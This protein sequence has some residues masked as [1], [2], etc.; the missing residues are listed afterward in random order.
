MKASLHTAML[1]IALASEPAIAG[2]AGAIASP[3]D[4][5]ARLR[6]AEAYNATVDFQ[7]LTSLHDDV[8]YTIDLYATAAP[9]DTLAPCNYLIR[10]ATAAS[11]SSGFVAYFSGSIY[12]FRGERLTEQHYHHDPTPF[13]PLGNAPRAQLS[14]QFAELLPHFL[15]R[16]LTEIAAQP[17]HAWHFTADT[18]VDGRR[19]VAL[20]TRLTV[21]DATA[22]ERLLAFDAETAMPIYAETL[23]NPG[24]LTEQ[25]VAA[26]YGPP[27]APLAATLSEPLLAAMYPEVFGRYRTSTYT[28]DNLPGQQLP[29]FALPTLGGGHYAY[30]DPA[31]RRR[32]PMIVVMLD[33]EATL[34]RA[35]V[36]AVRTAQQRMPRNATI[37][38]AAT[39]NDLTAIAHLLLPLPADDAD[40]V[41][42]IAAE[43]LARDCGAALLPTVILVDTD[44]QVA[45]VAIGYSPTLA[46]TLA[47]KV[48]LLR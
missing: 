34:A 31:N 24:T 44:G 3:S 40:E 22:R 20:T 15:A 9:A 45:D 7:L 10:W 14:A 37:L 42:L 6:E 47:A 13:M 32:Q 38:W 30:P 17:G 5:A 26:H 11:E 29:A 48:A 1:A 18:I 23:N 25:T 4:L 21:G 16:E 35:T 28:I 43:S 36:A 41:A 33:P 46:A 2:P 19:A 12:S 27:R 8:A 39:G